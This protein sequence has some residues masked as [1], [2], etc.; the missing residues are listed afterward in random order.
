MLICPF[1]DQPDG[2]SETKW[3]GLIES[4]RKD[5]ECLFGILKKRFM[6]LK[7]AVRFHNI[8][9]ISDIFRTCCILHNM[10]LG[11][12]EYDDWRN[13]AG[14]RFCQCRK[15]CLGFTRTGA[16][17]NN[18][19][20]GVEPEHGAFTDFIREDFYNRRNCLIRHYMAN[21]QS[22]IL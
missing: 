15:F 16:Q 20:D 17:P 4:L 11:H 2:T 1:K 9:P 7:H 21:R 18:L 14:R 6:F 13:S 3:S 19:V 5:V 22:R 10:L 12:D 8:E